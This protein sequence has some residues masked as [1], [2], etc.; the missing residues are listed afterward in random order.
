MYFR[1]MI[2]LILFSFGICG[3][4][5]KAN[6]IPNGYARIAETDGLTALQ[7]VGELAMLGKLLFTTD[8]DLYRR[9]GNMLESRGF[10]GV[11]RNKLKA[12]L[13]D[14]PY[15]SWSQDL[16]QKD[17]GRAAPSLMSL[18]GPANQWL[19]FFHSE[20]SAR[21]ILILN[22]LT[23]ELFSEGLAQWR[24]VNL[25]RNEPYLLQS[26]TFVSV[27]PQKKVRIHYLKTQSTLAR[28]HLDDT[29]LNLSFPFMNIVPPMLLETK[30]RAFIQ[31]QHSRPGVYFS[32]EQ[33]E[34]RERSQ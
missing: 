7:R 30:A 32:S 4:G 27:S 17:S 26:L 5:Q 19:D 11:A 21:E 31:L 33:I 3:F 13:K 14:K 25:S 24:A 22:S 28:L 8:H 15:E 10:D 2:A 6:Y 34:D 1:G 20:F 9:I 23:E 12:L 29:A 16:Q 18:N